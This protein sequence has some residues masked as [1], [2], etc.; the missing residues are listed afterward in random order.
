MQGI[1][2]SDKID[3]ELNDIQHTKSDWICAQ[4]S[5]TY[6]QQILV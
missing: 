1:T 6:Q 2:K 5:T 4:I 3:C